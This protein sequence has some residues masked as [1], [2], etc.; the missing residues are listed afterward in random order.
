[1][2]LY[3]GELLPGFV[4]HIVR[5]AGYPTMSLARGPLDNLA[6]WFHHLAM[7]WSFEKNVYYSSFQTFPIVLRKYNKIIS[8]QQEIAWLFR[9]VQ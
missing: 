9:A 1:M 7:Y 4:L 8:P 5:L 6:G 2:L 3:F